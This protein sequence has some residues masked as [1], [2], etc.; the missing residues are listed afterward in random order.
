[1]VSLPPKVSLIDDLFSVNPATHTA[2][3]ANEANKATSKVLRETI[4]C[5]NDMLRKYFVDND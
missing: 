5:E 2:N 3:T 1:M 4:D